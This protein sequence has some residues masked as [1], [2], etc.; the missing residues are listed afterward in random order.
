MKKA[1]RVVKVHYPPFGYRRD[2]GLPQ[3]HADA[4]VVS[5][6][7]AI[8]P[9]G[10]GCD[11]FVRGLREGRDGVRDIVS[12]DAS[13]HRIRRAAEVTW[14]SPD[15][16]PYSR[17]TEMALAV[18]DDAM[19]DARLTTR[20]YDPRIGVILASNQ[21]G[22]YPNATEYRE[23]S[24]PYRT[25]AFETNRTSRVL[26]GAPT[27]TLDLIMSRLGAAGPSLNISTACS[28]G[29][30]A[31]GMAYHMVQRGDVDLVVIVAVEVLTEAAL[32]GFGVL[33]ALTSGAGPRPFDVGRDGTILGE[34]AAAM[35]VEPIHSARY[36]NAPIHAEIAGYG[37]STD[38][39]HMTRPDSAGSVRA[40]REALGVTNASEV[41][42]IKA[43]GT[44]TPANDGAEAA[45]IHEVFGARARNIPVTS[46]KATLGHSLGA[47]GVIEAV[48]TILSMKGGF[49]PPT[50]N[51][52]SIDPACD[53]DVVSGESRTQVGD[54]V[55]ANA[56]GFG[57]NNASILFRSVN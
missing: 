9:I 25:G 27:A 30:H 47:S 19:L 12:F 8:T 35:I 5:A 56:F 14:E 28:A 33:R 13:R 45:A 22:M 11:A 54:T 1:A 49:V 40:M 42:W 2:A 48:G 34:G 21:A 51:V 53:L 38:A 7:A 17:A 4:I 10:N 31:L 29:L 43:H 52:T 23:L 15:G 55:L 57:G 24:H 44:G 26:D 6:L 20:R 32:A 46:M 41:D 36:R 3:A 16:S 37:S 18:M 39:V 50:L